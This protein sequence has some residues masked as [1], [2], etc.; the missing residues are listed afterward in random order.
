VEEMD[1]LSAFADSGIWCAG[2]LPALKPAL[3]VRGLGDSMEM[4]VRGPGVQ[5]RPV[6]CMPG[7]MGS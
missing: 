5:W 2:A 4:T 3:C 7:L 1:P 6:R